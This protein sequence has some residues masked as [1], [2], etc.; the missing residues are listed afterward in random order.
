LGSEGGQKDTGHGVAS[1]GV[2]FHS[3]CGQ[4]LREWGCK[5][6]PF[7]LL[8]SLPSSSRPK[9]SLGIGGEGFGGVAPGVERLL[10]AQG[11]HRIESCC[12]DCRYHSGNHTDGHQGRVGDS[13]SPVPPKFPK[14]ANA[15]GPRDTIESHAPRHVECVKIILRVNVSSLSRPIGPS[16]SRTWRSFCTPH[17]RV[18]VRSP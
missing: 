12:S 7:S 6:L 13:Q 11:F 9:W 2:C 4:V 15:S 5:V 17:P 10:A 8:R 18:R 3:V 1:E 16:P 14:L